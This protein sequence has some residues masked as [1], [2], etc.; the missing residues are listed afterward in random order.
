MDNPLGPCPPWCVLH[1]NGQ[2]VGEM[3][4]EDQPLPDPDGGGDWHVAAG[5]RASH[6]GVVRLDLAVMQDGGEERRVALPLGTV[7]QDEQ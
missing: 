3:G 6:D 4:G 2:H 7:D 5:L 1:V